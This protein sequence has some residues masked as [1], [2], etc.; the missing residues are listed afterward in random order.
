M[1][2]DQTL[3]TIPCATK[4]VCLPL[5]LDSR[6]EILMNFEVV[7]LYAYMQT[8]TDKAAVLFHHQ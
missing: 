5:F 2:F 4:G 6:Y 3:S 8:Q 1:L 7:K